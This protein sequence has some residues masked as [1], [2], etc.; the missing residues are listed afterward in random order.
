MGR[1]P[2]VDAAEVAH[3]IAAPRPELVRRVALGM[4]AG[5]AGTTALNAVTYLDMLIRGR[6]TSETPTVVVKRIERTILGRAKHGSKRNATAKEV[7]RNRR[8]AVGA[9]L[10][11]ATGLGIGVA[12]GVVRPGI[13][14]VPTILAG[15]IAGLAA[16][17]ASDLPATLLGVTN[18]KTWKPVDWAA[19]VLPHLAYGWATALTFDALADPYT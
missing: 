6:P 9:L 17:T 15:S 8:E 1:S 16:M 10:G 19:D 11:I 18:P 5:A 13:R 3:G 14:S 4:T 2:G 7:R 12:L